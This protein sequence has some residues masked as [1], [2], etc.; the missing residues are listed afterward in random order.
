[1]PTSFKEANSSAV[2]RTLRRAKRGSGFSFAIGSICRRVCHNQP[3]RKDPGCRQ[4]N[5][6]N[7]RKRVQKWEAGA[8]TLRAPPTNGSTDI[9]LKAQEGVRFWPLADIAS[10]IAHVP[11]LT[12]RG[13][14]DAGPTSNSI[15]SGVQVHPRGRNHSPA[16]NTIPSREKNAEVR[17][18]GA[19]CRLSPFGQ[20]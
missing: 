16:S 9:A 11:L 19:Q 4:S 1:L 8:R 18:V 17:K 10:C 13:H 6:G 5:Q 15:T 7:G 2:S 12:Q 3:M 14:F 20:W